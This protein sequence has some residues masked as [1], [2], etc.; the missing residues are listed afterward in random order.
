MTNHKEILRLDALGINRRDTGVACGCSRNT[1]TRTL[2]R[3]KSI[4]LT[5]EKAQEMTPKEVTETLFPPG[6]TQPIHKMPD[7]EYVHREMQRSS[8]TLNLLWLEYCDQCRE[9]GELAYKST[10]FNKYYA[11]FLQKTKATM[12]LQHKPGETMQVDWAG[13][14]AYLVDTDTG[15]LIK[16]YVFVA[17]LPY[18]GYAYVEAF[19]NQKQES[20]ITAHANAYSYIGGVTR[21]LTPDNLKVGVIKNTRTETVINRLYQE[22]A[23]HYGTAILP[24]RPSTPTDK[25]AVEGV[26]GIVSTFI[27]AALRNQQ[28]LSLQE[29]NRAIK[30]KLREFNNKPF[31]KKEGTRTSAFEEEKPYLLPLPVYP[32]EMSTWKVATVQYNYHI[33][34]ESQNYSVSYEYIKQ[35]V[36]VRLTKNM[37]EIFYDS[38]RIASH[39]RLYGSPNQYSTIETHM[40]PDHQQ[41][42]QWNGKR[43]ISWAEKMGVHT[44]TVIQWFLQQYKVEQ[45]GYK[46]CM[47]LLKLTD[48]Y[49]PKRV[50]NACEKALSLTSQPSLKNIQLILRSGQDRLVQK[51][52]ES[53][54]SPDASLYG[55][56]RGAEY[57]DPGRNE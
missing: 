36:D 23:E 24:T 53:Q 52:E 11:D 4:G 29:L 35:K 30:E 31:Q 7:Y 41:Y 10:Q 39:F 16:A 54:P 18:S 25:G 27:L 42:I 49:S 2:Q 3:A 56:T 1:V 9:S 37:V 40:P 22:M 33:S 8:V 50:E 6:E 14:T 51:E 32:F 46:V 34:V 45:Q 44:V 26:V 13:Q 28:F 5:W 20:W 48:K 12:R 19:A 43:F 15:K 17:V 38:N 21:I 57:Y 47:A 55:F